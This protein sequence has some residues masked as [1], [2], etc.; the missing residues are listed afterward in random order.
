LNE[1]IYRPR[2][3]RQNEN[4]RRLIRETSL[5]ANDFIYPLFVMPGKNI[6]KEVSSMPGVYQM[7]IDNI[8]E[9]CKELSLLNIPGIILFGIP[10]KK[11]P[12]GSEAYS[13]EGII[14][15]ATQEIKQ[16]YPNLLVMTDLCFCEYTSHGHC[17]I[18][19]NNDVDN[20]K[21][22]ELVFKTAISQ[23]KAGSDII[24]PSLMMDNMVKT[25]RGALDET[26]FSNTPICA[27]S[28]KYSS[29]F[30]GPFRQAALSSPMQGDR[31]TYQM[32]P[33]NSEEAMREIMLDLD[34]GADIVMIKPA[35]SYLDIIRRAKE[36]FNVPIAA[37]SV[38]GEYSMIKA[39]AKNNW[40]NEKQAVLESHLS[41][42]R[43]G[44]NFIITYF[45]KDL[46]NYLNE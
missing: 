46:V 22:L 7:S 38:S 9:E 25:I 10:E 11:D 12:L 43:A 4:F 30:Y 29:A 14:Q 20:D 32:D 26:G 44:A 15:K 21:T 19:E 28:A 34:E 45:A 39:S 13:D 23:A 37:Y 27:Y 24:A 6:K 18:F 35:L 42:K 31:K 33:A 36:E 1:I 2:R 3:L 40:I 41:M 8:L 16:H 17:G 5:S